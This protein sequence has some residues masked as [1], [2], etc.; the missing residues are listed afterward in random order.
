MRAADV[1]R[2]VRH[3]GHP[4]RGREAIDGHVAERLE[5]TGQAPRGHVEDVRIE[6]G[7]V[8]AGGALHLHVLWK[9]AGEIATRPAVR[10]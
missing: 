6:D 5:R 8:L 1:F 4:V 2:Q 10:K 3:N 9:L 7:A